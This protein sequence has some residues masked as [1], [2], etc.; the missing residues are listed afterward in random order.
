MRKIIWNILI[1]PSR[2]ATIFYWIGGLAIHLLTAYVAFQLYGLL[3][4]VLSFIFPFV[5]TIYICYVA[6]SLSGFNSG[7]IQ[8]V[9]LYVIVGFLLM[10]VNIIATAIKPEKDVNPL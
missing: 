1:I 8:W 9:I 6:W 7:Y 3:G 5:S 4:A 10:I 2:F